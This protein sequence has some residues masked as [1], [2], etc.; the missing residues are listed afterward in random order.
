M[1][2]RARSGSLFLS[3]MTATDRR[4]VNVHMTK[5]SM[6]VKISKLPREIMIKAMALIKRAEKT[7]TPLLTEVLANFSEPGRRLAWARIYGVRIP[8]SIKPLQAP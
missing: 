8:V 5:T 4:V 6:S 7:G 3:K 1:K 2:G